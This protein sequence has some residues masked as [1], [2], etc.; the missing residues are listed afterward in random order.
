MFLLILICFVQ[1]IESLALVYG[2][3]LVYYFSRL[4]PMPFFYYCCNDYYGGANQSYYLEDVPRMQIR[5]ARLQNVLPF[6]SEYDVNHLVDVIDVVEETHTV[7]PY[8]QG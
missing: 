4:L 1:K 7:P 3:N 5:C 2:W 8:Q 6:G